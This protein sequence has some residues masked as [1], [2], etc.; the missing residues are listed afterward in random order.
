MEMLWC[1][2]HR[3]DSRAR[4]LADRHYNRQKVGATHFVPPGRCLVLLTK[5]STALW[6]TSWPFAEY[7]KHSWAGAWVCSCFRNEST[8]L[9]SDLNRQAIS[10]TRAYFGQPPQIESTIGLVGMVSFIDRDKVKPVI[11]RGR[12]TWGW[13]YIK[14][15]WEVIGETDGGLLTLGIRVEAMPEPKLCLGWRRLRH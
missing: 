12:P 5:K 7:T 15:G 4:Q 3:A 14:A 2:S 13:S 1:A 10:A 11:T 9:A 6:I 8:H